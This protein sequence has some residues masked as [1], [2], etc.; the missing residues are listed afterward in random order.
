MERLRGL[1]ENNISEKNH[2][3]RNTQ[4][5]T[6]SFFDGFQKTTIA[7]FAVLL[8]FG[9]GKKADP[10]LPVYVA[11]KPVKNL[12]AV[13]RP[14]SIVLLWKAP[15]KNT[16]DSPL[17]DLDGFRIF[18]SEIP[19]EKA[20]LKCP[21]DF[22]QIFDYDYSGARGKV[23]GREWLF[24]FDRSFKFGSFFTYKIVCYTEKGIQSPASSFVDVYCEQPCVPPSG[25]SAKKNNRIVTVQWQAPKLLVDGTP[26][27]EVEGF[28]VYRRT[29]EAAYDFFP[30]NKEIIK[31]LFFEDIPEKDDAVYFYS[32]RTLRR[33]KDTLIESALSEETEMSYMDITPAGVPQAL[34]AI[35]TEKGIVL[36]W[37]QNVEED[38][39]GF[40]LYRKK[41]GEDRFVRLNE[42]LIKDNSWLD[43]TVK[44]RRSYIYGVTSV[45]R[46]VR[47][48]ESKM[49]E[50]VKV[51]YIFK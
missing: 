28:N 22:I 27:E 48:N 8:F 2:A 38:F 21:R 32:V 37:I 23:P 45:D 4:P 47:G 9:C 3:T 33:V 5:A 35:P 19:I 50:T 12:T 16:N 10:V 6:S 15:K 11:P 44:I 17:V 41:P 7:F 24:Y 18:R 40:N 51:K 30:V 42:K 46:S 49:S 43:K 14:E 36:K 25:V 34:T 31:D 1:L 29:K 20:C 26:V 13:I 39:A